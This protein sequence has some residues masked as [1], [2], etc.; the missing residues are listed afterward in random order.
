MAIAY[1][2]VSS[3]SVGSGGSSISFSHTAS[4]ADT[5]V[6]VYVAV[7]DLFADMIAEAQGIHVTYGGS[8]MSAAGG[9]WTGSYAGG[10]VQG[11]MFYMV[12]PPTGSQTV[13]ITVPAI[14][15]G[16]YR[17]VCVSYTG[18][19]GVGSHSYKSATT[20]T[21]LST[22]AVDSETGSLV[23]AGWAVGDTSGSS[24]SSSSGTLRLNSPGSG[25]P[26]AIAF[27]D[28]AGGATSTTPTITGPGSAHW[29]GSSVTLVPATSITVGVSFSPALNI[30]A[31]RA[32][33]SS[34]TLGGSFSA[35]I[36]SSDSKT[37]L[38]VG[39]AISMTT[40]AGT[41]NAGVTY[42]GI[43]M[44]NIAFQ[45]GAAASGN[46]AVGLWY[47]F[48]P[49]T[50]V[51]T[52]SV[53]TS[54]T[55]TKTVVGGFAVAYNNVNCLTPA[56][57]NASTSTAPAVTV[58]DSTARERI[59]ALFTCDNPSTFSRY[60][61]MTQRVHLGAS[62]TGTG[63]HFF[64]EEAPGSTSTA[65]DALLGSSVRW[66]GMGIAI[67]PEMGQFLNFF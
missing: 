2:A 23:V 8:Y 24:F 32:T 37:C 21:A 27:Q 49:P 45:M 44:Q 35:N 66:R 16:G 58:T 55:T 6:L 19:R 36:K 52:V 59:V 1:D 60:V 42:N 41:L 14:I 62:A 38:I 10:N 57:T 25:K 3:G 39:L 65:L 56:F 22:N 20:G 18:V 50:G 51:N 31:M 4:G 67:K 61:D 11:Q 48:N 47:L 7:S 40:T 34:T 9:A 43:S 30:G 13:F 33:G 46:E 54:G 28:Q 17:A 5:I 12:N 63:D 64:V 26:F 29:A 15:W 53:T